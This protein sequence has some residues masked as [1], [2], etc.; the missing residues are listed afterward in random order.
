M[1]NDLR[2]MA[3]GS[4]EILQNR[5]AVQINQDPLGVA[6]TRISE[7]GET[8]I[9]ARAL[10]VCVTQPLTTKPET[11]N[12]ISPRKN[13]KTVTL[14]AQRGMYAVALLNKGSTPA[15]ITL[16]FNQVFPLPPLQLQTVL[17]RDVWLQ[18]LLGAYALQ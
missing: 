6:G 11:C 8:E 17:V 14:S 9:W 13:R 15:D 5:M 12:T 1:G 18:Q 2:T 7:F 4:K 16:Q 10:Q 3:P